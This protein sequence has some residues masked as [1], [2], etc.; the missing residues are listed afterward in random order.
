MKL[1]F[2]TLNETAN[3]AKDSRYFISTCLNSIILVKNQKN[4]ISRF[5]KKFYSIILIISLLVI[6]PITKGNCDELVSSNNNT[7]KFT[8]LLA[9]SPNYTNGSTHLMNSINTQI[10][11][12]DIAINTILHNII[13]S[14]TSLNLNSLIHSIDVGN[15]NKPIP[16]NIGNQRL[17]VFSNQFL[18]PAE[19]LAVNQVLTNDHQ[20]LVLNSL[21]QA[22]GGNLNSSSLGNTINNL[23]ISNNVTLLDTSDKLIIN[24]D[25]A[26]YGNI[27]FNTNSNLQVNSIFNSESGRINSCGV[28]T[29]TTN[30]LINEGRINSFS[31]VN[32]NSSIIYNNG[33]IETNNGNIN[34][35]SIGGIEITGTNTSIIEAYNG[36]IN[37]DVNSPNSGNSI[38]LTSGNY[39]SKDLFLNNKTGSIQASTAN[40][41]GQIN[42]NAQNT[43]FVTNSEKMMLGNA[44]VKGDPTYVNTGGDITLNG[45]LTS[46]GANLTIIAS[47]NIIVA[48]NS[49]ASISTQ[50]IGTNSGNL[51]MIAGL[52]S[53]ISYSG[54][55]QSP[56]LPGSSQANETVTVNL[57]NTS[58]NT[59]GN[60]DLSTNNT[61]ISGN[62]I[63]TS[64]NGNNVNGGNVTII[65]IANGSTGGE[66]NTLMGSSSTN[67][68]IVTGGTGTGT[69]GNLYFIGT[70]E[71]GTGMNIGYINTTGGSGIGGNISLYTA[72]LNNQSI[73]FDTTG[74]Q[75][76]SITTNLSSLIDSKINI[77]GNLIAPIISNSGIV[78]I[79]TGG[80]LS[81]QGSDYIHI[82]RRKWLDN[83]CGQFYKS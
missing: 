48:A 54:T 73:S 61:L 11:N 78:S 39:L 31:G 65:A 57:G 22:T 1:G 20:S 5:I 8:N 16:I 14:S 71:T 50:G 10:I 33:S 43:I 74:T 15:L 46:N 60:I 38:N 59:G 81:F 83:Q 64:A 13:G 70:S 55:S 7:N 77:N 24:G 72:N 80:E 27:V 4:K 35:A 44:Y 69:N 42:I 9:E 51:V 82:C 30:S 6:Q 36:N 26:N 58:G 29:I 37:L 19:A 34:I 62:L 28:L 53:N 32:L 56:T 18:T 12:P 23:L 2:I 25:L 79:E 49:P 3:N 66:I 41:A 75:N 63:T 76:S 47:G 52:G 40:I 45:T 17:E 68:G 21:G 67:L